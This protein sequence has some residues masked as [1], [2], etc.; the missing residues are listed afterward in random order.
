[1]RALS[2]AVSRPWLQSIL[3]ERL[4][5]LRAPLIKHIV[6][7]DWLLEHAAEASGT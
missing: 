1:M 7:E 3:P 5:L 6:L 2:V 4:G